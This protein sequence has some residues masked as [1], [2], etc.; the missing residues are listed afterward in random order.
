MGNTQKVGSTGR[1]GSRYGVGIRKR[2]VKIE[3]IQKRKHKC[4]QCGFEKVKRKA[5]GIY[6]CAKCKAEFAGGA[7]TPETMSGSIVKKMVS[8]KSFLPNMNELLEA[9]ESQQ[10]MPEARDAE[11][12]AKEK[13]AQEKEAEPKPKAEKP[14]E[15]KA[16]PKKKKAVKPKKE[17]HEKRGK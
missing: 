4:P 8:Q 12:K 9:K 1:F 3:K 17:G 16:K 14:K 11:A 2:V 6:A 13:P 10:E 5:A 15:K 7:Y